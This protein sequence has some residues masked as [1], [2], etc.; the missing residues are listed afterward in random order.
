MASCTK[1]PIPTPCTKPDCDT[2]KVIKKDSTLTLL[3][4]KSL[5]K[6]NHYNPGVYITD[7]GDYVVFNYDI[8][9]KSKLL[10][11]DKQ[12]TTSSRFYEPIQGAIKQQFYHK[13]VGLIA[14]DYKT[15]YTG[16]DA[17]SM[18]KIASAPEGTQ[19]SAHNK[20]IGHELYMN[21]RRED[22]K[23]SYIIRVNIL[24]GE[25]VY[26]VTM[27]DSDYPGY[28]NIYIYTPS[29]FIKGIN[30]TLLIYSSVFD[31]KNMPFDHK[32]EVIRKSTGELVFVDSSN[33]YLT[34]SQLDIINYHDDIIYNTG[35]D[36]K[37][38]NTDSWNIVWRAPPI[39]SRDSWLTPNLILLDDRI[40]FVDQ[41]HY[42][43][44]DARTGVIL[45]DSPEIY[46][47]Q[48]ASEVTYFDGIFYWTAAADGYSW[49]FGLRA[50]DHKVVLKMK[51]PNFGKAPYYNDTNYSTNGVVID[52][53]TR[54]F[55]T[56]DGF[57][58]QC[59]RIPLSYK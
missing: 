18:H 56:A 6:D 38:V 17:S 4:Q 33:Y 34:T 43:E 31:L 2:T 51:S 25:I 24:T 36:L 1:E 55:Y 52:P 30:D 26:D 9:E 37:R 15:I 5:A 50:S 11:I 12:D 49:I 21:L 20:L 44:V 7:I 39:S 41:G 40:C 8:I 16:R 46:S 35:W 22:K 48:S 19:F 57:F 10:F 54:L 58:A 45:Y 42:V 3:W 59:F 29:F 47:P 27:K 32:E 53:E 14:L 28:Q 13:E 23:E